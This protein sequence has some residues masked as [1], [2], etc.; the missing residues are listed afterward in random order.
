[1]KCL[2]NSCALKLRGDLSCCFRRIQLDC[3]PRL[4]LPRTSGAPQLG[5]ADTSLSPLIFAY[6]RQLQR[7][8]LEH[9]GSEP[10]RLLLGPCS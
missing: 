3:L 1:M 6:L 5:T 4:G 10:F 2:G 9:L 7:A 8:I